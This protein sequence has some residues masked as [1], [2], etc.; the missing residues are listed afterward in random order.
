MNFLSYVQL[1]GFSF[2]VS[3]CW[4][5]MLSDIYILMKC[6]EFALLSLMCSNFA[7]LY[8]KYTVYTVYLADI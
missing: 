6:M 8:A 1:L 5:Y 2:T 3:I 4:A 7:A